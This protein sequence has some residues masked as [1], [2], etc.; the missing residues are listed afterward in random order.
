MRLV[1]NRCSHGKLALR[2][3][4]GLEG[5]THSCRLS[6]VSH[7]V[8]MAATCRLHSFRGSRGA[9]C[10]RVHPDC[11]DI[12][13]SY[14]DSVDFQC[15]TR[16]GVVRPEASSESLIPAL[17]PS[18]VQQGGLDECWERGRPM[19][20][21]RTDDSTRFVMSSANRLRATSAGTCWKTRLCIR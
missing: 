7:A 16:R 21:H 20:V 14:H 12:V 18:E 5:S 17:S 8:T 1:S 15:E 19:D 6:T 3:S 11:H 2:T 4:R 9:A 10:G 13:E